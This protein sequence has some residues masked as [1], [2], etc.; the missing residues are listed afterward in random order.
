M[1]TTPLDKELAEPEKPRKQ[2]LKQKN[3]VGPT[4]AAN[5]TTSEAGFRASF[6]VDT[7]PAK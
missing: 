4:F 5:I 7:T 2:P 6:L 1:P 3:S